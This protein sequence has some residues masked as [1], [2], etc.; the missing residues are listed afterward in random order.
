MRGRQRGDGQRGGPGLA[1]R[2][3]PVADVAF[4]ADQRGQ[5]EQLGRDQ[6]RRLVLPAVQVG[7][8]DLPGL[9]LV[10]QP[11]GQGVVEVLAAGAHPADVQREERP[12]QV[13]AG[14]HVVADHQRG[15]GDHV[16][17]AERRIP[18]GHPLGDR[19]APHLAGLLG[20][21]EERLPALGQLGGERHVLR[22]DG[23][24]HDRDALAHRV[25]DQLE[26]LAEPGAHRRRQRDL[27]GRPVVAE[28]LPAP[29]HP[30]DLDELAGPAH[31]GV[32]GHTVPAL[33]HL[34]AGRADAEREPAVRDVVQPGRGHRG[35]RRGARVQLKD[36]GG[37]LQPL[38]HGRDVAELADRVEAVRLRDED[39]PEA[40]LLVVGEFGDRL[41]EAAGV[42]ER[43]SDPHDRA[44][45][46]T[47]AESRSVNK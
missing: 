11:P 27:V 4:R 34:R 45:R 41:G 28:P 26:R 32:V 31:R 30:A 29:D 37:D 12:G 17:R 39:D 24:D 2:G 40:G 46:P 44:F 5:L 25:I 7:V 16:Q 13:A 22:A 18:P 33:D 9:G 38:R 47:P 14:G 3:E 21:V 8:L 15:L 43:H 42:V 35:Q 36:P 20:Q 23:G 19:A 1:E 6:G 10:A